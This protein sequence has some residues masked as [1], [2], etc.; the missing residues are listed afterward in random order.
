MDSGHLTTRGE[1]GWMNRQDDKISDVI[2]D[3]TVTDALG[4]TTEIKAK[5]KVSSAG[6]SRLEAVCLLLLRYNSIVQ[7][8]Q[9]IIGLS[10]HNHALDGWISLFTCSIIFGYIVVASSLTNSIMFILSTTV[11]FD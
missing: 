1:V 7:Q 6:L 3:Q 10:N 8:H 9:W 11:G 2:I 4:N 5:K